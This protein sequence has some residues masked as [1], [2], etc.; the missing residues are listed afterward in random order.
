MLTVLYGA[1]LKTPHAKHPEISSLLVG[2]S[3]MLV[4]A[5]IMFIVSGFSFWPAV[6]ILAGYAATTLPEIV[7]A[8]RLPGKARFVERLAEVRRKTVA[9]AS[10]S[11]SERIVK[12]QALILF[13]GVLFL[14]I[15]SWQL[16]K[17]H[18]RFQKSFL[19]VGGRTPTLVVLRIYGDRIICADLGDTKQIDHAFT[20]VDL[21][22]QPEIVLKL[23]NVGPLTVQTDPVTGR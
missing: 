1:G 6:A 23:E 3:L 16:G 4:A 15:A 21:T 19:C 11:I 2:G 12:R 14:A 18:A 5:G 17:T 7:V 22:K 13:V 9:D 10:A 8:C 20:I